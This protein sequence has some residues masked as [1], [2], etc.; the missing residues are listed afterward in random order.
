[1]AETQIEWLTG[2]A[3]TT[4]V[5]KAQKAPPKRADGCCPHCAQPVL[6]MRTRN[7]TTYVVDHLAAPLYVITGYHSDGVPMGAQSSGYAV[8]RCRTASP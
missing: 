4:D 5:P 7:G 1:M 8:H 3:P 6:H 2:V